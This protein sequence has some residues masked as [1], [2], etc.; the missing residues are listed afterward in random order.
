MDN[1]G[2]IITSLLITFNFQTP[3]YADQPDPPD[4]LPIIQPVK[5]ESRFSEKIEENLSTIS[6]KTTYQDDPQTEA[7]IET[8]IDEGEDGKIIKKLKI[9]FHGG[10][11]Y[12]REVI[13]TQNLPAKDKIISRG[14]KIIWKTLDTTDGQIQYWKKMRVYATH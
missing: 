4:S 9:T 10:K 14:T 5:T 11:E 1:L 2:A 8:V 7:G 3:V 12:S 6:K 13:D